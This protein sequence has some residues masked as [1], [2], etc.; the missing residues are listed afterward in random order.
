M[1]K[2][3]FVLTI[4]GLFVSWMNVSMWSNAYAKSGDNHRGGNG[5]GNAYGNNGGN[6][7]GNNG[8]GVG[9]TGTGNQGNDKKV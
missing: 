6:G 4:I 7:K 3:I 1:L 5:K 2:K 8:N 9:N